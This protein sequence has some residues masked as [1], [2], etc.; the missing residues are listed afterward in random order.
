MTLVF[1]L[2][3]LTLQ[4]PIP[5]LFP[6]G[7]EKSVIE[8]VITKDTWLCWKGCCW[9]PLPPTHTHTTT[10]HSTCLIDNQLSP[11]SNCISYSQILRHTYNIHCLPHS[12]QVQEAGKTE[13]RERRP[14]PPGGQ[15]RPDPRQR[16]ELS[17]LRQRAEHQCG[18]R[19]GPPRPRG[20]HPLP[21]TVHLQRPGADRTWGSVLWLWQHPA[22]YHWPP[23]VQP[24]PFG[25]QADDTHGQVGQSTSRLVGLEEL[26]GMV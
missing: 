16:R 5:G 7:E 19:P 23:P 9:P 10:F 4:K 22:W 21:A 15:G 6:T 12:A 11:S 26:T 18:R 24:Q 13:G 20:G 3:R 17:V 25:R 8:F 2:K 1:P 14:L